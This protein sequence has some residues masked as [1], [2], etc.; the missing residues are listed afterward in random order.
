MQTERTQLAL[1]GGRPIRETLLP[2]GRQTIEQVD[3]DAVVR[4][5]QSDWLTTGPEVAGFEADFAQATQAAHAVSYS[6]GTAALHGIMAALGIGPGDEVVVPAMTFAASS[7]CAVYQGAVPV[8]A[9]VEPDTLLLSPN[10]AERALTPRTKAIVAVDY[11][12]Q[13]CDYEALQALADAHGVTL[14]ADACHSLGASYKGRAAGTLA[15]MS[16]FS[17][18]PVKPMTTGEGG[19]VTTDDSALAEKLKRFRSHGITTDLRQR[20][21]SGSWFYEMADLGYNYRLTDIQCAL[22]RAQLPRLEAWTARRAAIASQY[23]VA[24]AERPYIQPVRTRPD[25]THAHHLYVVRLAAGAWRED[26]KRVFSALRAEGIGVNVHYVPV[27]WHPFYRERFG[28]ALGLCPEAEAAYESML[29][30]PIFPRM[31]DADVADVVAALDKVHAAY[32]R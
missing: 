24:F 2:Y 15:R 21:Q 22:G 3:L 9:D 13:P 16:A 6:N 8:F 23:D 17:L 12:G 5:L 30:L 26:R 14:V 19:M 29:S 27:Y 18:H 7:N 20:E 25:R 28:Y 1:D 32:G 10:S 31:A 4:T 11:A